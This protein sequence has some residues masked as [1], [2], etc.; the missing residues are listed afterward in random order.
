MTRL[1]RSSD[2]PRCRRSFRRLALFDELRV[3]FEAFL[4]DEEK[5]V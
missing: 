4:A 2:R 3:E 1:Q 5:A